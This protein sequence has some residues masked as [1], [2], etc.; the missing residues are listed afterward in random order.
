M[1]ADC[2]R[3]HNTRKGETECKEEANADV[4]IDRIDTTNTHDGR[5]PTFVAPSGRN[6][7]NEERALSA[8]AD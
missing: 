4:E 6:S 7:W 8:Y 3:S 5:A 1:L 2:V